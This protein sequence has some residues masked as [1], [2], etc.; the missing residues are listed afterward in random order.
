MAGPAPLDPVPNGPSRRRAASAPARA[1]AEALAARGAEILRSSM[2][3]FFAVDGSCRFIEVNDA[4]CGM[5]GYSREEL[6][7]MR[8]TDLE[9]VAARDETAQAHTRTGLHHFPSA[10]RH[11][12]GHVV[13][14]EISVNVL[15]G[16]EGKILVGFA[17]DV[18]ERDRAEAALLRLTSVQKLILQS[19]ADG[20]VGI[21]ADGRV[22]LANPAAARM[23]GCAAGTLLG[24]SAHE[25]LRGENGDASEGPHDGE[26]PVCDVLRRG[27]SVV[28]ARAP[29]R[30]RD[31][32]SFP[33]EYSLSAMH[34][35]ARVV[36]A[37]LVFRDM[38]ERERAERERR[39]LE[40]KIEAGQ[41]LESLGLLAG[42]IAHD[43]NNMLVGILG[44]ASLALAEL[45]DPERLGD[46]LRRIVAVCERAGKV[47]RQ[48]LA[49]AGQ[50][51]CDAQ[52]LDLSTLIDEM[53]EFLRAAVPR[54]ITLHRRL[55]AD[56]PRIE[57][58]PGQLQQ[59]LT[60]L[61]A[62]S[63]EA[64]GES[65]GDITIETDACELSAAEAARGFPG[66]GLAAGTYARLTVRDTGCG[67]TPETLERLFEPFFSRKGAGRGLGLAAMHG[68]V[69]AH[70]GGVRVESAPGRGSTFTLLFPVCPSP[71]AAA[72]LTAPPPSPAHSFLRGAT[73]L[74]IDDDP[75]VRD[76]VEDMLSAR[77]LCVLVAEDGPRGVELF[78]RHADEIDVVLLDMT[79][80][81]MSG[82]EVFAELRALRPEARIIVS[83]GYSETSVP[84]R[85]G[86]QRP[87]AFVHKPFTIDAL[88]ARI[89]EAL[90]RPPAA[91]V[92]ER[93]A[94]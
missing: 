54:G 29:L 26:C 43:F 61:V 20:V 58:D 71:R 8:I 32:A 10:H 64:I 77:G 94:N 62:N 82:A 5:V 35:G 56:V 70:R 27:R 21:D 4:F 67:M 88:V 39:A 78:A 90:R 18:T 45:R 7:R 30:R 55:R 22:T 69:R 11:K 66:Q 17:R 84:L 46:R 9:V 83:S 16:D 51:A 49:Y 15:H 60:N 93:A 31:G 2:D 33:A 79:M 74:V 14:L 1:C 23:L 40:A 53:S 72:L 65:V 68:I 63:V 81:R 36:G 86:A 47:I 73:V 57:A 13:H 44:N 6:L 92:A 89:G 12:D 48:I 59:V 19:A 80:P 52:P 41:R 34:E 25:L 85:F 42:G 28:Q 76:V 50:G 37:V 75:D 3:G 24:R 38:T 87:E 91:S